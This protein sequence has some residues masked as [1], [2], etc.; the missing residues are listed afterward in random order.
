M[1]FAAYMARRYMRSRRHSRFLSRG[2]VTAI[3]G[4]SIGSLIGALYAFNTDIRALQEQLI[5]YVDSP[6]FQGHQNALYGTRSGEN[7]KRLPG[8]FW[9]GRI[10]DYLR[11]NRAFHRVILKRSLLP[12]KVLEEIV[13]HLL[14]REDI[15]SSTIPLTVVAVDLMTGH[16]VVLEH[17]PLRRAVRGSSSL[18]G[19]FPPIRLD[20]KMLCDIGVFYA[21]PAKV[22]RYYDPGFVIAVDVTMELND[23]DGGST[24]LD[25]MIRMQDIGGGLLREETISAADTIIRPDVGD[26]EWLDF[27]RVRETIEKGRS[28]AREALPELIRLYE[29]GATRKL[30][31]RTLV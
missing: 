9:F 23:F 15:A 3:V 13:S 4:V 12:G 6:S 21:V 10:K 19:I 22:A 5:E 31:P 14:P 7:G 11:A 29:Q 26:L 24:A 25:T 17:G 16:R 20:G 18:P 28:A 2:G 27:N 1:E 30:S 8:F